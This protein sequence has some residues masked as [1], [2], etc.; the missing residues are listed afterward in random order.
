MYVHTAD[1]VI[2][3]VPGATTYTLTREV[4]NSGNIIT[5]IENS[6]DLTIPTTY[7]LDP[8]ISY[9]Y[10]LT[11]DNSFSQSLTVSTPILDISGVDAFMIRISND[12]SIL[13]QYILDSILPFMSD[14]LNTLETVTLNTG[15]AT[16]VNNTESLTIDIPGGGILTT[17]DPSDGS[18]QNVT[19]VID[20]SNEIV[21]Y[22][23]TSNQVIVDSIAYDIDGYFKTGKYKVVIKEI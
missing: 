9:V 11:T 13:P 23:E 19:L 6:S 21:S 3:D 20:G 16:F 7:D 22:D 1:I 14:V 18:N 5:I 12:L 15:R 10:T 8:N 17:F 2:S 4:E